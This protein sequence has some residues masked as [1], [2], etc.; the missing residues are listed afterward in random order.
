M[1]NSAA[2]ANTYACRHCGHRHTK[3]GDVTVLCACGT[4][5]PH[6]YCPVERSDDDVAARRYAGLL[7]ALAA[8]LPAN[9]R[10]A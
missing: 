8:A 1:E 5:G 3:A 10:D 4:G 9:R 6:L 2:P 7:A